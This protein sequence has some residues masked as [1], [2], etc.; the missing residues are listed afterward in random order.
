MIGPGG[1]RVTEIMMNILL[2]Y[3]I[4]AIKHEFSIH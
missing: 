1:W 3:S 4:M 2:I